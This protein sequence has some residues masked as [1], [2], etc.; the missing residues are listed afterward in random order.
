[1]TASPESHLAGPAD[2]EHDLTATYALDPAYVRALTSRIVSTSGETVATSSP[3]TGQPLASIPQSGDSDID[4]AFR[5]ARV[6]QRAWANTSVRLREATLLRLH[7]LVLQRQDEIMDVIVWETGKARRHAFEEVLHIALTARYYGRASHSLLAS[8]GVTGVFPGLTQVRVN[9]LPKG[10][11][12]MIAPWNYPFSLSLCDGLAALAAGNAVVTK[13][14]SQTMLTALLGAQLLEEAGFP[15]D[16]WKVVA[17]PGSRVGTAIIDQADYVSFTGSTATGRKIASQCG[18]RLIGCSLELGGKNPI[19]ILRD[20]DVSRAVEGAIRATYSS[21][22][23][24]CMST[25]RMYVADQIYDRFV[26]EFVAKVAAMDLRDPMQ[27]SCE[28]GSL[29]SQAQLDTVT[30]HV[31]DAVSRGARVL[32]GGKARPDLGPFVFEPTVLEGVTPGMTC[33]GEETFGPVISIYRFHDEAE[34]VERANA[35]DY[36][37]NASVFSRDVERARAVANK[38]RAGSV[39]INE[40]YGATFA[41]LAAPMGGMGESGLGRRQG[42]EGIWRFTESQAVAAQRLLRFSPQFGLS[43]E[44]YAKVMTSSLRLMKKLGAK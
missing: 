17:G 23:Q 11:V 30:K 29:T 2:P 39:N 15:T 41:S 18:E 10:I 36:G 42:P 26:P 12:G 20:A 9:R 1:M 25:E 40:A 32:C 19:L 37:L 35:T 28:M 24:L 6:A 22:G 13:P 16:L 14:D 31:E 38:I 21:A 33:F 5:R 27:W 3:L 44:R 43:Q 34:A 7:D 8:Q 4:E